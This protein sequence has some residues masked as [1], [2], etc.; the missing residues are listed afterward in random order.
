MIFDLL[1]SVSN[2][3]LWSPV[4]ESSTEVFFGVTVGAFCARLLL[5]TQQNYCCF[6]KKMINRKLKFFGAGTLLSAH[7]ERDIWGQ[8]GLFVWKYLNHLFVQDRCSVNSR[9]LAFDYQVVNC[10]HLQ[11]TTWECM[12][13]FHAYVWCVPRAWCL[14]ILTTYMNSS[15]LIITHHTQKLRIFQSVSALVAAAILIFMM[16][17]VFFFKPVWFHKQPDWRRMFEKGIPAPSFLIQFNAMVTFLDKCS[18]KTLII[19][20]SVSSLVLTLSVH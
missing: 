12:L 17:W 14:Q 1:T 19:A 6:F 18:H 4:W 20:L 7:T 2:A 8:W 3:K 5:I 16:F 9:Q 11:E 13:Y 10:I 15:Y